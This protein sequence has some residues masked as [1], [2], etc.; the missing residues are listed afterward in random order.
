M[1][2]KNARADAC[3]MEHYLSDEGV[4]LLT[5][6]FEFTQRCPKGKSGFL[7]RF[8]SCP[9]VNPGQPPCDL[10]CPEVDPTS[11]SRLARGRKLGTLKPGERGKVARVDARGAMRTRL[12]DRGLLPL[13]AVEVMRRNHPVGT[14]TI[15]VNGQETVL[16]R[17]EADHVVLD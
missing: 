17:R 15:L 12:L 13:T 11:R 8:H 16:T 10:E 7:D 14:V 1:S 2:P 6:F 5:K 9:I 3:S 4:D